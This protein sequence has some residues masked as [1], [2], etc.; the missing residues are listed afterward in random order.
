MIS[1]L[2]ESGEI[3]K[4]LNPQGE[5]VYCHHPSFGLISLALLEQR[6][7]LR[8]NKKRVLNEGPPNFIFKILTSPG[9]QAQKVEGMSGCEVHPGSDQEWKILGQGHTFYLNQV[10]G[11]KFVLD[12]NEEG[13]QDE[14]LIKKILLFS[15]ALFAIFFFVSQQS[16]P[17][18]VA[19]VM[20][21]VEEQVPVTVKV[22]QTPSKTVAIPQTM[23]SVIPAVAGQGKAHRAVE[24]QLGFLKMVGRSDMKGVVGGLRTSLKASPGA[25]PGGMQGSGG[26][27]LVGL[28]QGVK[29][30]TVGNTGVAGLGGIGTKGAGGGLGGYGETM[31]ASGD[32]KGKNGLGGL[33]DIPLA[34]T[35][36]LEGG[37]D[38]YAI[39]ATIAKYLN[40][41]RACYEKQL[42]NHPG[43]TGEI[44]V[45]FEIGPEGKLTYSNVSKS[46]LGNQIVESCITTYMMNWK[47]P[48]PRGGVHVKVNYPFL[49]RPVASQGA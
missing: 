30:T 34:N 26:E 48:R 1:V 27:L 7:R 5:S 40:Q 14:G 16:G 32:G 6:Q 19:E 46:S 37:L 42:L 2:N 12:Q 31:I 43:L 44:Q 9:G 17:P 18:E 24:Q 38:R 22:V 35:M 47:F 23:S 28:G 10:A 21:A 39:Q 33:S 15:L 49:L 36:A 11:A 25:G 29:K 41:V 13:E 4:C 20:E 3:I 45:A 8:K